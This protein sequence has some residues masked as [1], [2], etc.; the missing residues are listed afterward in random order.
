MTFISV[1]LRWSLARGGSL[2][3]IRAWSGEGHRHRTNL[4][5]RGC[6]VVR[7]DEAVSGR[8]CGLC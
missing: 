7:M 8:L 5:H 6:L 1:A 4:R 3:N 2:V